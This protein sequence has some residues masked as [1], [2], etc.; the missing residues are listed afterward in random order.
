MI[1]S[2]ASSVVLEHSFGDGSVDRYENFA[3]IT[4]RS[5]AS[6]SAYKNPVK[7]FS[8]AEI[9]QLKQLAANPTAL[10]RIRILPQARSGRVDETVEASIRIC[11]LLSSPDLDLLLTLNLDAY[12]TVVGAHLSTPLVE[13]CRGT[14]VNIDDVEKVNLRVAVQTPSAGLGPDTQTYIRKMER[15]REEKARAEQ[16]DNR[17]F[18]MKYGMYIIPALFIIMMLSNGGDPN[19]AGG[20]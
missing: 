3:T 14:I 1:G 13:G 2:D 15:E 8:L 10:Y 18:L 17:S 20:R 6:G 19:A 4:V 16:G 12:G 5:Y 11:Q 7:S 9:E